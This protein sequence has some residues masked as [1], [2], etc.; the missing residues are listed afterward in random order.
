[1][2]ILEKEESQGVIYY[3]FQVISE[4]NY[5]DSPDMLTESSDVLEVLYDKE[6]NKIID[7]Y[8]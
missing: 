5:D 8:Q 2:N 1:M 6:T 7:V 4:Y 3:M